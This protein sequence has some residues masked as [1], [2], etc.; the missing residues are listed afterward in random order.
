[1]LA[2]SRFNG[3]KF[4]LF[5]L[6]GS[7]VIA[8]RALLAGGCEVLAFDDNS[9]QVAKAAQAGI[10]TGDLRKVDFGDFDALVL[11]PG[12]PL[13]HPAPHWSAVL[14]RK[15]NVPVI[16]DMELFFRQRE[17]DAP[18]SKVV[19]ITGTNGKSTTTALV[20]HV[21]KNAGRNVEMGGNIGRPV[22][23][24]DSLSDDA[25]YVLELSSYQIDLTD[26]LGVD[27]G[28]LLNIT[29]DHLDR[30]GSIKNYAAIKARLVEEADQA[31]LGIDDK[32]CEAIA[33]ELGLKGKSLIRISVKRSLKDGLYIKGSEVWFADK[34][35]ERCVADLCGIDALRGDHNGQNA[36][37]AWRVCSQL[38]LSDREIAD[39]FASFAS[40]P[41]RM[42]PLGRIRDVLVVNDSKGTNAQATQHALASF[43]NIYWIAGGLAKDE[44][45]APLEPWFERIRK[46]FL[47]GA[48][49]DEFAKTLEGQVAYDKVQTLDRALE[50]AVSDSSEAKARG[51]EEPVILLSPACASFDQYRSFEVRGEAFR[52]LVQGTKGFVARTQ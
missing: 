36:A 2:L 8:A 20:S 42:E 50:G 35:G 17:I 34:N 16:G 52:E 1:M 6:G 19:A 26:K 5:G 47:I 9:E 45:I 28:V 39:G 30:H 33:D 14:A 22:L 41:H 11:A 10:P 44:G 15:N 37:V 49:Q 21:L 46:A 27:F 32:W 12:V 3:E 23:E 25:I 38:G 51:I 24:F 4:A 31:I 18:N 7:G 40:L 29:P 48:A 13:T 43:E